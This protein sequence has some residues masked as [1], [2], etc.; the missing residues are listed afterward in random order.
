V[1]DL[2]YFTLSVVKGPLI[3]QSFSDR[4]R[5]PG[6]VIKATGTNVPQGYT[7]T[8]YGTQLPATADYPN[9]ATGAVIGVM[10]P[11]KAS[12]FPLVEFEMDVSV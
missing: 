5:V 4:Q 1:T 10:D 6:V 12:N 8:T 2:T 3:E 7:Q 11:A 9:Y